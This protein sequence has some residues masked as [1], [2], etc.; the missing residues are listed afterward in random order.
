MGRLTRTAA[1]Y[2]KPRSHEGSDSYRLVER[3]SRGIFQSTLPRGER[4]KWA[5]LPGQRPDISIHA[6]T[7][8]ATLWFWKCLYQWFIS[9]H[10]PTRGATT[11]ISKQALSAWNFN[12][13]SHEGS[14]FNSLYEWCGTQYFNPRSHEGS[15]CAASVS[16]P[17]SSVISIHAPTRGA[18][19]LE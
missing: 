18:T 7:R 3:F 17:H 9:I 4:P 16:L 10:A 14:D 19:G 6:P 11:G 2:F 8:G 12:P 15:D 13:R 1:G 5:G